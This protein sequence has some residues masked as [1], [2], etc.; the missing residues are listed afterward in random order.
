MTDLEELRATRLRRE[1]R[2]RRQRRKRCLCM[3]IVLVV[4][5][6]VTTVAIRAA[7]T[8]EDEQEANPP[9]GDVGVIPI[10]EVVPTGAVDEQAV[11]ALTAEAGTTETADPKPA[12]GQMPEEPEEP[13]TDEEVVRALLEQG[14]ISDEIPLSYEEQ[15]YL[16][17]ACEEFETDYYIMLALI[18]RETRFQNIPGD[19]G[20]SQGFCQIQ[21]K[22]WSGLM[23]E[24]GTSDLTDPKDNF[25][26]GC[27]IITKLSNTY[28]TIEDALTAYNTGSPG[29]SKYASG[30]LE[31][32][33]GWRELL[34][35][36]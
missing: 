14:Y 11:F 4:I 21:K 30:V 9:V 7:S 24:I 12:E 15:I 31:A 5:A 18:E 27:A 16:R 35:Q 10:S 25:R 28:G 22:W 13:G 8:S 34:C 17:A 36:K 33:D 32:A 26:T 2:R 6:T 19:G 1:R 20:N 29:R 3:A 23:D